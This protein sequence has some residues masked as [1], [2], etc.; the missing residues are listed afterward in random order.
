M[1]HAIALLLALAG[2][3]GWRPPPPPTG[4]ATVVVAPVANRTGEEIV[5]SGEWFLERVAGVPRTTLADALAR[6]ARDV[7]EARGFAVQQIGGAAASTPADAARAVAA[8]RIAK[9]TLWIGVRRWDVDVPQLQY[10]SV[11]ADAALVDPTNGRVL[12]E[13]HRPLGP[14][15]TRGAPTPAAAS[16]DA[17]RALARQLFD[18]WRPGP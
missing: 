15:P 6:A 17:A 2:C 12:W 18:A 13:A 11:V 9:P 3:A 10:V 8:A 1:R 16:V 14:I 4:V 7:L 5:V